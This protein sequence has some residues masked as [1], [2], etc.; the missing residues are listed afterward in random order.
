MSKAQAIAPAAFD[1][2]A[3]RADFPILQQEVNGHP[4]VY[5]DNAATTQKPEVVIEA[6]AN[7]Y[8]RD[9][10]NVHRGA[11]ALSDRA[12]GAFE[13]A[14]ETVA[15]FINSPAA[16]QVIWVRGTTEAINLVAHS[17]GRANLGP[18]DRVLVSYLEHH[19]DIVPWQLV[20]A[21]TG[22]EVVAI[23][24]LESGDIDMAA[25]DDLLDERVKLVAVNHVSNALG[26]VNPVREIAAKA[27]AVGARILV[28]GAQ[29]TAHFKVDVQALDC[30]FYAFSGHKLYGPTGI[31]AL[32]GREELLEAMPPFLGGGEMI[33]TVSFAG[34]TFNTLPFKFEAG[35]P[36]IADAIGLAA[37]IDYLGGIDMAAAAAHERA[38]LAQSL[39]LATSV[40]GLRRIGAP[41]EAVGI[42]SFVLDGVHPSDLGMLLDQQGIAVR[43]GHHC[44]QPLMDHYQVPGTVRAS[45]ALYNTAQDVERLFE[46]IHKAVRLFR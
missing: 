22:A 32:W 13:Q 3:L 5:L 36:N 30:D 35:T 33:E 4:L 23:P 46:G 38:L 12:T 26:T 9:N 21:A 2:T 25:L 7:Y 10:A 34:T 31:G 27:H 19:S 45:Y 8:R 17:W 24:I 6:V 44:T 28:D 40:E 18:G 42:F 20:C 15:R 14:R 39:A 11:H 29:A 43:T 16:R 1:A 37:A 41:Q